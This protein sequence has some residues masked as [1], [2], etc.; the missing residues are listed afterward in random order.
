MKIG[1]KLTSKEKEERKLFDKKQLIAGLKEV[2][3]LFEEADG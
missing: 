3:A 1:E 2:T